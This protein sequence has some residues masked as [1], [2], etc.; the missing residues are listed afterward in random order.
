MRAIGGAEG[1]TF[2]YHQKGALALEQ[3]GFKSLD[4]IQVACAEA[5]GTTHFPD[6]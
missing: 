1:R 6:L 3:A 2:R 5:A 4:A